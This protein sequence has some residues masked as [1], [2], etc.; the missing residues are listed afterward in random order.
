M[1]ASSIVSAQTPPSPSPR[2]DA[3]PPL[4]DARAEDPAAVVRLNGMAARFAPVPLKA[5]VSVLPARERQALAKLVQAARIMDTLF[6]R[7][8][9]AGNETL[10]LALIA[11]E[12]PLG[13]ARLHYFLIN[14][15]PWSRLDKD[16]AFVPGVGAKPAPANF[17]PA[18]AS[19]DEVE[20]W[21]KNLPGADAE[22]A[23]GFFTTIRRAPD[24]RLTAV[25]YSVEYQGELARAAALLREAAGLT[26]QPTLKA[27]LERRAEAFVSNDYYASDVAWME[28]DASIEP[29]IGPYEVYE[30]D[31]FNA[32][33]A[34][35][36][37]VALRDDAETA[38]LAR[39]ASELQELEDHL[40]IGA[41]YRNPKL[42]ALAPI[43]VVNV[44]FSA[45]DGNRGV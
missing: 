11:D 36:A 24:G 4:S 42:G 22:R 23:R 39:F 27:F 30:D 37:F 44:I 26:T 38:K 14:K 28:M 8:V 32:K 34:F 9:W 33:A 10:L 35:E 25:P 16:A 6:L 17:Y 43:R 3:N 12:T 31:W 2:P 15:G 13:R 18:G 19:K 29:T 41:Q 5:D 20:S 1:I 45:G 40:P 7:Q 21:M